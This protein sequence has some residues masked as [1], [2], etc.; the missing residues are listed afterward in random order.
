V[1]GYLTV[2]LGVDEATVARTL[3]S[4][5]QRAGRRDPPECARPF[6][7]GIG[8]AASRSLAPAPKRQARHLAIG[9]ADSPS[10]TKALPVS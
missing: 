2:E 9:S 7:S 8:A 4:D 3:W 10:A 5:Y 6:L 1:F